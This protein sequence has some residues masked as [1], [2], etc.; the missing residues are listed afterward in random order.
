MVIIVLSPTKVV[1]IT[2]RV[3]VCPITP[4]EYFL[5]CKLHLLRNC[6]YV[7]PK[8]GTGQ[9]ISRQAEEIQGQNTAQKFDLYFNSSIIFS[10]FHIAIALIFNHVET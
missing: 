8:F 2:I 3:C 5:H 6:N 7:Q 9:Q 1:K 4:I 10:L